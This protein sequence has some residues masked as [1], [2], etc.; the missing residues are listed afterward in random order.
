MTFFFS[1]TY[2]NLYKKKFTH[3]TPKSR[4]KHVYTTKTRTQIYA[5]YCVYFVF[6]S[7]L[8][9]EH[10]QDLVPTLRKIRPRH[11]MLIYIKTKSITYFLW[12]FTLAGGGF[13]QILNHLK[14]ELNTRTRWSPCTNLYYLL[15]IFFFFDSS[16]CGGP[17]LDSSP[18][19]HKVRPW[20]SLLVYNKT[21][22][23]T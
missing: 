17:M 10:T 8:C 7:S 22:Y 12:R 18:T 2:C 23:L 19:P 9:G 14:L 15:L 11:K 4:P 6:D 16:L 5:V 1:L 3:I 20:H 13:T 21:K